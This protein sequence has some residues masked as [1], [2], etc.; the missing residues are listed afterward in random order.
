M[1]QLGACPDCTHPWHLHG[2]GGCGSLSGCACKR[3]PPRAAASPDVELKGS[4]WRHRGGTDVY[5]TDGSGPAYRLDGVDAKGNSNGQIRYVTDL[6]TLRGEWE[7]VERGW[8]AVEFTSCPVCD[9]PPLEYGC[10]RAACGRPGVEAWMEQRKRRRDEADEPTYSAGPPTFEYVQI[11]PAIAAFAERTGRLPAN[12]KEAGVTLPPEPA[13][14]DHP[15]P[16]RWEGSDHDG[17]LLMDSSGHLVLQGVGPDCPATVSVSSPY[18]REVVALAGDMAVAI[19]AD[20]RPK[21]CRVRAD[22][23]RRPP[24]ENEPGNCGMCWPCRANRLAWLLRNNERLDTAS[25]GGGPP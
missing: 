9:Y 24:A 19:L 3:E 2:P 15:P 5:R 11:H 20:D 21:L 25:R 16:W 14:A 17:Y 4:F 10:T 7:R 18:V 8:V 12:A 6:A 13:P 1:N 23:L 22:W